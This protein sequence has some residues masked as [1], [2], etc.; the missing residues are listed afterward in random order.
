MHVELFLTFK[1]KP[2]R[3]RYDSLDDALLCYDPAHLKYSP[4]WIAAVGSSGAYQLIA[5]DPPIDWIERHLADR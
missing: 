2:S 1:G 3:K 4:A 5:G